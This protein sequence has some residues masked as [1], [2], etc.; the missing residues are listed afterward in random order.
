[1]TERERLVFEHAFEQRL[2]AYA[3]IRVPP[4]DA[5]AVAAGVVR[6]GR[7]DLGQARR[8]LLGLPVAARW[9]IVAIA[10]L[11]AATVGLM[12]GA[13]LQRQEAIGGG[14]VVI[15]EEDGLYL[16][17]PGI[18][19]T[20][21]R[22]DGSFF[23]PRWS[24]SG[25]HLAVLHGPPLPPQWATDPGGGPQPVQYWLQ[26]DELV[27]L[28]AAGTTEF[29]IPGPIRE[30]AWGP[31]G[32][33]GTDRLAVGM[34]D[35]SIRV[36]DATGADIATA[37]REP[38]TDTLDDQVLSPPGFAWTPDGRVLFA[39]GPRVLALDP[40]GG[41]ARE[42][43]L[44]VESDRAFV[45]SIATSRD[46]TSLAFVAADCRAYCTG[47]LRIFG[48]SDGAE[49]VLEPAIRAE[50]QLNWA[51]D[52]ATILAWPSVIRVDGSGADR[53]AA[54]SVLETRDVQSSL[55]RWA[56]DGSGRIVVVTAYPFYN[57]RR[58]DG[59]LVEPDGSVSRFG[60]LILGFD[61]GGVVP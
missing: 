33:N 31:P 56:A 48:L 3:A 9:A 10:I 35:G 51:P 24:A 2:R 26:P 11:G 23:M 14:A 58:F 17:S 52:G 44:V 47:E 16:G 39:S 12:V 32:A 34:A 15:A 5:D 21:I 38:R 22:D 46:G 7:H 45:S 53:P 13:L 37:Q 18:A 20:L 61:L 30:F 57:D 41:E 1:M 4:V 50:T 8:G 43:S 40:T 28:D 36:L 25:T 29:A 60:R 54:G 19:P 6:R 42:P 49:R 59:W 27:V 55:T